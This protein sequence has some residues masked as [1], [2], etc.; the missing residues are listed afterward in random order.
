MKGFALIILTIVVVFGRPTMADNSYYYKVQGDYLKDTK[1]MDDIKTYVYTAKLKTKDRPEIERKFI[2]NLMLQYAYTVECQH[3]KRGWSKLLTAFSIMEDA[4][5]TELINVLD[6]QRECWTKRGKQTM[7]IT[8]IAS[9]ME[10][11][12]IAVDRYNNYESIEVRLQDIEPE[13]EPYDGSYL[14]FMYRVISGFIRD[15]V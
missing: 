7:L 8:D 11:L 1:I 6:A 2:T 9:F 4:R 13:P 5:K 15:F 14:D 12:E 10:S 3:V